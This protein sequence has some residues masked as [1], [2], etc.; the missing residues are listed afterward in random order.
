VNNCSPTISNCT[1]EHA[2]E[3]ALYY[4]AD[5]AYDSSPQ[6]NGN[7]F[8]NCPYGIYFEGV[9]GAA[10]S[11]A[12]I[13]A[14]TVENCTYALILE[15]VDSSTTASGNTVNGFV[16][17]TGIAT[18]TVLMENNWW[19]TT[20]TFEIED[21][22]THHVDDPSRPSVDYE[23]FL[24][25]PSLLV[26]KLIARL[27]P[28]D[29]N[30]TTVPEHEGTY[31]SGET[32]YLELWAQITNLPADSNGLDCV[33]ADVTFDHGVVSAHSLEHCTNF[34]TFASGIIQP[35]LVDELGGCALA[36]GLGIEPLWAL[37]G[38]VQMTSDGEDQAGL[39]LVR[40]DTDC[41]IIGYGLVQY[42]QIIL[43]SNPVTVERCLYDLDDD[44]SIGPGDLSLFA[45]CWLYPTD[46]NGCDD[47][48]PCFE[49][50]FDCDSSIG[51]GDLSWFATGWLKQH[52]DPSILLAPCHR[53]R[54][55]STTVRSLMSG[56]RTSDVEVR[57]V[58]LTSPSRSDT[59]DTL[60]RSISSVP[61][62]QDYYFEIW[63]SDVGST[64]TGLT[65][66]YVDVIMN[67]SDV[68]LI[69]SIDQ[70]SIFT[71]F[72]SGTVGPNGIDELGGS[73]LVGAGTGLAW[74]RASV[75]RMRAEAGGVAVC[76][77][78]P[79]TTG[80]AA[81]G[82]GL[83]PWSHINLSDSSTSSICG[84]L[85]HPYPPGDLNQDCHVDWLD[86]KD[87]TSHWAMS[88]CVSGERCSTADLAQSGNIDFGDFCVLAAFWL[89]CTAP[90]CD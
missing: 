43:E 26:L 10:T 39:S 32:F 66:V 16:A 50:N 27:E 89:E 69:Q 11:S 46:H 7:T 13:F 61:E 82:R 62:G 21:K 84:D 22:I 88:N 38:R 90:E 15:N 81:L 35:G 8:S 40:A 83:V 80:V 5:Q 67:S 14:N 57:L 37:V 79:S 77:L 12:T 86:I 3:R 76:S 18:D 19:G 55:T 47:A 70:G 41:S 56:R 51:P 30:T 6:I 29:C 33:F 63:A 60:P 73:S 36:D 68:D 75:V 48:I 17:V 42:S 4:C 9:N 31:R 64:N 23:P 1:F 52:D 49:A 72:P 74:A 45:C 20:N 2:Y 59:G 78:A 71:A 53:V 24:S 58:A 28:S 87:L 25:G 54:Q 44:G 85:D 34:D 65:S